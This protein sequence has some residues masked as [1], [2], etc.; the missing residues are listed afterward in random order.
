MKNFIRHVKKEIIPFAKS[1]STLF[2]ISGL[3]MFGFLLVEKFPNSVLDING[4]NNTVDEIFPTVTIVPTEILIP[5]DMPPTP[6][7]FPSNPDP[8]ITCR[9]YQQCGGGSEQLR[10]S[11]CGQRSCCEKP[12][13]TY[14]K[15][16]VEECK[17]IQ[18]ITNEQ[19]PSV[20][21][22]QSQNLI[23]ENAKINAKAMAAKSCLDLS[24]NKAR[25]CGTNCSDTFK[26][27]LAICNFGR[28]NQVW[29]TDRYNEC[30]NEIDTKNNSCTSKCN[31]DFMSEQN[32]C[33]EEQKK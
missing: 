26:Q 18:T 19:L 31:N 25:I 32:Q 10:R 1:N 29:E 23:L 20:Q 14:V 5:T 24:L 8:I 28:D 22:N 11:V 27:D 12:D 3:I 16:T 21:Q 7:F 15:T 33:L 17:K 30:L 4:R 13:G 6:T 9:I 2:L